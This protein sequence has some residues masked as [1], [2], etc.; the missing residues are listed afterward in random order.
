MSTDI[1]GTN[2]LCAVD[3]DTITMGGS[4]TT[5]GGVIGGWIRMTDVA[6]GK[7]MCEGF[8]PTVGTEG[9]PFSAGV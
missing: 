4:D 5:T 3:S 6:V 8:L 1:G 7:Y 2:M 9:T